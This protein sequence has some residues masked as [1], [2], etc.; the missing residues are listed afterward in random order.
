MAPHIERLKS[1]P[2]PLLFILLLLAATR[3]PAAQPYCVEAKIDWPAFMARHDMV[4]ERLPTRWTEAPH[5]GNAM[6]GSMLYRAGNAIRL[7]VFRADVH[8]H[9]DNSFGWTA[10]SRPR[11]MIGWFELEPVGKIQGGSWRT[12]LW[13]AELAGT[14][15]TD[16][17]EI[18]LRHFVHADEMAIVTE[19][20]TAPGEATCRWTWHPQKAESTRGGYPGKPEEIEAFAK[21][22]GDVYKQGLKLGQ[23]NPEGRQ[24]SEGSVNVWV[25]D[26]LYGG[27]YATAWA[28]VTVGARHRLHVASVG[29][30][31][32]ARTARDE[33]VRIVADWS[34]RDH[35]PAVE[36]HRRWWH[37]Y[38][39]R[40]FVSL[41]ETRLETL[42]WNTVFRYG[43]TAR[44]G[45]FVVDTPGIWPQGGGWCYITTDYNIQTALWAVYT[46]NRLEQ[47]AELIEM[48]HRGVETLSR[49]VRPVEWQN[50][51]AYMSIE[52]QPDLIGP[53]DQDMR[54]WNLVGCL[55][56]TL[57]NCWWQY[58]YSMDDGMLR[59][60]LFP[61]LRRAV[62]LYLHM[63]QEENGRL[64]LPPTYSPEAG[65]F[66]DCNFD[67][68]LLRWGCQTLLQSA[69]RLKINDPLI[70]KWKDVL[71]RLVDFPTDENGVCL[72][73]D[74]PAPTNHRHGSHLLM[75][76]PLYLLNVDQPQS[77]DILRKSVERFAATTGLPA[78]VATHSVPAAA[79]IG[80]G[81]LAL[82]GLRLQAA[83]LHPN[84]M[85]FGS[86][87]LESSLSSANGIQT[88]LLQ[89]WGGKIRIFPA[90]PKEWADA[91]FHDL[92]AEGAFLVSARRANGKT[93]WVRVRSLA[94]EPCRLVVD[95]Q[96]EPRVLA[97]EARINLK[98]VDSG[99]CELN[100]AKDQEVMLIAASGKGPQAV[101]P[102]PA[103]PE[104]VNS[105]GLNKS[106]DRTRLPVSSKR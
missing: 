67:L 59:E 56:W 5:F 6:L 85:W 52:S 58:R 29:N 84:G 35:G 39:P 15:Q 44:L 33:A 25:Q 103:Q 94:G 95:F 49:N 98:W 26:L 63:L 7:Q 69:E 50:D 36:S 96:G 60:K 13:N 75:I 71:A 46:A 78:M 102:L 24:E 54:Y 45:R 34:R 9:R 87:C 64:R 32:P 8:D 88:M 37:S 14:I 81:E 3:L 55:P 70:P 61:L 12:D 97:G 74:R 62:N 101:E 28:D 76:Y 105:F 11:F 77:R 2:W 86:P 66:A 48:L 18:R 22:Y 23:P 31:Y 51:S 65:T 30:N 72:G 100:L 53:R 80:D 90:M 43:C 73:S 82:R 1:P 91:V 41:T 40:S 104:M 27:Q 19:L 47:G 106:W 83:D 93:L 79:S 99:V 68:A 17:G 4:W 10:Y 42:Y 89:S 92:R 20:W 16:H 57:H 38:Y 21:K